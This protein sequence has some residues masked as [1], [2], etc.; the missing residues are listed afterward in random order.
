MWLTSELGAGATFYAS[1]PIICP[2]QL[3]SEVV[4][5]ATWQLDQNRL[6]VL[7]V[8]DSA[9]TLFA[10]E[11][12]VRDTRYQIISVNTFNQA[13]NAIASGYSMHL[14]KPVEP[15]ELATVVASLAS[16]SRLV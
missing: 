9:E 14:P 1:I 13:E 2:N 4:S 8:E 10:Y 6:A 16:R 11:K 7:V 15:T 3:T 12:Y 5:T